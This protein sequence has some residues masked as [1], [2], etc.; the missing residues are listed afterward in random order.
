[1]VPVRHALRLDRSPTAPPSA[2]LA[3][4]DKSVAFFTKALALTRVEP[5]N[6]A[7]S[8]VAL[9]VTLSNLAR[10]Q[11]KLGRWV[12]PRDAP[13]PRWCRPTGAR[14]PHCARGKYR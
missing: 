5:G 14:R 11:I 7:Q 10:V 1:M 2:P 6:M 12:P 3:Q 9:E 8:A 4:L 13:S